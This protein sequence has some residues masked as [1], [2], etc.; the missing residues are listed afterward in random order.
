MDCKIIRKYLMLYLDSELGPEMT[1]EVSQHLDTCGSCQ[2]LFDQEAR[3]E[4]HIRSILSRPADGDGILWRRALQKAARQSRRQSRRRV[5]YPAAISAGF[6][7]FIALSAGFWFY[8]SIFL[9]HHELDLAA[10]VDAEHTEF[11]KKPSAHFAAFGSNTEIVEYF[12]KHLSRDFMISDIEGSEAVVRGGNLC[13]VNGCGT[14]HLICDVGESLVSVFWLKSEDQAMFP[15]VQRRLA[16]ESP[17]IHCKVAQH[18]FYLRQTRDALICG[19]GAIDSIRLQI[20][21]DNLCRAEGARN[22]YLIYPS[23]LKPAAADPRMT[24]EMVE[25]IT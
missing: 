11:L 7:L 19:I 9:K 10:F 18:Q 15:D 20:L 4:S 2:R 23:Q 12:R 1:F 3:L 8:P 24:A 13:N 21:V 22:E 6:A 25:K 17:T 5:L 14:A 16:I